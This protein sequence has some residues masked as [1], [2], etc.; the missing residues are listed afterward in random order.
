[1]KQYGQTITFIFVF[2]HWTFTEYKDNIRH[3]FYRETILFCLQYGPTH[4]SF[5]SESKIM[6]KIIPVKHEMH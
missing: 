4:L 5:H 1:M 3:Y 2:R 6:T